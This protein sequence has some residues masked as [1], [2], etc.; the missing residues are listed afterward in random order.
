MSCHEFHQLWEEYRDGSL[1]PDR[2][3]ALREH[4]SSCAGCQELLREEEALERCLGAWEVP[5]A[6]DG[7][8]EAVTRRAV[9]ADAASGAR[10]GGVRV[11][12]PLA[13]ALLLLLFASVTLNVQSILAPPEEEAIL[14]ADTALIVLPPLEGD[15]EMNPSE[16]IGAEERS[17]ASFLLAGAPLPVTSRAPEFY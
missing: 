15:E 4:L 2:M 12:L 11:P 9:V 7:F 1:P 3:E 8:D 13:V 10:A 6:P 16:G 17:P 14:T 5:Q